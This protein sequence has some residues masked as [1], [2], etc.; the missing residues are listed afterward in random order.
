MAHNELHHSGYAAV[1]IT[2]RVEPGRSLDGEGGRTVR[3]HE[4]A[5]E[6]GARP[7]GGYESWK[8]REKYNH[9]RHN[10]L[11]YNDISYCV[12]LLSDGNGIYVSGTGTGN[13]VR[14]NYVHDN[15]AQ[16]FPAPIR[17]DDDQHETL[18]YGNVLYNN[19]GFSAGIASKGV[20]DIINNFIV[21]PAR[22]PR[23]GYVS[24]EWAPVTGSKAQR[25]I[26][27]SHPDGGKAHNE[28]L[29]SGQTAAGP[30]LDST[31]MDQN[32]YY[33]PADP[34]WMDEHLLKMRAVGNETASLVGDPL[35]VDPAGGDFSFQPNS[36]ALDLGIESLD[37]SKM[38]RLKTGDYYQNSD[39]QTQKDE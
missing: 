18:I 32:L 15:L 8:S 7:R 21:A 19:A 4:I 39:R 30:K 25:N 12:Q 34:H 3:R 14:Y 29:R 27:I 33:H 28:R 24:F 23:N 9:A 16:H 5:T 13:I 2:T 36:P 37:V 31:D 35:F 22:V 20:N 6:D 11:E 10:L 1:L 26:I 17:C 38:G